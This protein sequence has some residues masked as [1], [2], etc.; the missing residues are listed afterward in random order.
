MQINYISIEDRLN[1]QDLIDHYIWISSFETFD[2]GWIV[3]DRQRPIGFEKYHVVDV[4]GSEFVWM[5]AT[6]PKDKFTWYTWF[7]SVFLVP[8]EMLPFLA[9]RWA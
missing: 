7:E 5:N 2:K 6:F 4:L 9:M 1:E 8:D 3:S